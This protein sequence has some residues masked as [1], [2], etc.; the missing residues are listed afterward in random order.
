AAGGQ[1]AQGVRGGRGN[2]GARGGADSRPTPQ[3]DARLQDVRAG[4]PPQAQDAGM[5][6][7]LAM[8]KIVVAKKPL[9]VFDRGSKGDYGTV[10]VQ[11][12]AADLAAAP[13]RG[14]RA[15]G[16]PQPPSARD[17]GV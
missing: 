4:L 1:A 8:L 10:F 3:A 13:Q 11:G 16:E 14:R 17:V 15:A 12:A 7:R 9:A 5:Q 2:R 6:R